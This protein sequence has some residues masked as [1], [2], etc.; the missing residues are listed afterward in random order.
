M[1]GPSRIS[2]RADNDASEGKNKPC[3][4]LCGARCYITPDPVSEARSSIRWGRDGPDETVPSSGDL[5][6]DYWC[7]RTWATKV[8][9]T[10]THRNRLLFQ[11]EIA[12][13]KDKHN[14]FLKARADYIAKQKELVSGKVQKRAGGHLFQH[15]VLSSSHSRDCVCEWP[16]GFW[17]CTLSYHFL[18]IA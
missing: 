16:Q 2:G 7:E 13:D 8:A 10:T 6:A 3:S 5:S 4:F 12:K 11:Q 17:A 18:T 9:A 14:M 15:H 1:D